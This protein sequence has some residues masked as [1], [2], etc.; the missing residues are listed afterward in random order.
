MASFY[1]NSP[2]AL[3]GFV[4]GSVGHLLTLGQLADLFEFWAARGARQRVRA[5]L[6]DTLHSVRPQT[7][8]SGYGTTLAMKSWLSFLK[9]C[10]LLGESIAESRAKLLFSNHI[11]FGA[12]ELMFNEV[13]YSQPPA[14]RPP[15]APPVP[16]PSGHSNPLVQRVVC[17]LVHC[18]V[19][20]PASTARVCFPRRPP[21]FL[22]SLI[23][24]A[25]EIY[26]RLAS[27]TD[28]LCTLVHVHI[29]PHF[30]EVF[31]DTFDAEDDAAGDVRG[32][33]VALPPP[34]RSRSPANDSLL[35]RTPLS[36]ASSGRGIGRGRVARRLRGRLRGGRRRHGSR[37]DG[38]GTDDEEAGCRARRDG[39]GGPPHRQSKEHRGALGQ[40]QRHGLLRQ[41]RRR[42]RRQWRR[43]SLE[44]DRRGWRQRR[45]RGLV[46]AV[47]A[48]VLLRLP[49]WQRQCWGWVTLRRFARVHRADGGV[50]DAAVAPPNP[51]RLGRDGRD[52]RRNVHPLAIRAFCGCHAR[53]GPG[54]LRR[55]RA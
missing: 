55:G 4:A 17:V 33:A 19:V 23:A 15:R 44:S 7:A 29:L 32:L 1:S 43:R 35:T 38:G 14:R 46:V 50:T 30:R 36:D 3:Q 20:L 22:E 13:R 18:G 49:R 51:V 39:R 28:R 27:D 47:L 53:G 40:R 5:G 2:E 6:T 42:L 34:S 16:R 45:C 25:N 10:H 12:R 21:Q 54:V 26:P 24:L 31:G 11:K 52:G 48:A 8:G 9:R 41:L 37:P